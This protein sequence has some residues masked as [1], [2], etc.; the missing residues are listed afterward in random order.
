MYS[1]K[2]SFEILKM[3]CW[4]EYGGEADPG[5]ERSLEGYCDCFCRC[6]EGLAD[7]GNPENV[8]CLKCGK[9]LA[10]SVFALPERPT[11][12]L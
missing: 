2:R 12:K 10:Q 5:L 4:F 9:I 6:E 11:E 8:Y 7:K 1:N 3:K